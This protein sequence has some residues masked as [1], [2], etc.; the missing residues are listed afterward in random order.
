MTEFNHYTN[1][2]L[3][4]YVLAKPDATQLEKELVARLIKQTGGGYGT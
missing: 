4:R 1:E 3:I 2:E